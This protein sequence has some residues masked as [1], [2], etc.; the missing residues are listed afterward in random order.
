MQGVAVC[1]SRCGCLRIEL[2][3]FL[4]LCGLNPQMSDS[5]IAMQESSKLHDFIADSLCKLLPTQVV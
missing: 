5:I 4:P 2:E 1:L 3:R